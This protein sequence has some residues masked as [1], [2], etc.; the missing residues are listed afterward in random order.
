MDDLQT[1]G[2]PLDVLEHR[3]SLEPVGTDLDS[4]P[5]QQSELM[6]VGGLVVQTDQGRRA[7]AES[8]RGQGAVGDASTQ[9]PATRVV[10]R[11]VARGCADDDDLDR[12]AP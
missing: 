6:G 7:Q 3:S 12:L 4:C 5:A 8:S 11:D 9:P 1:P 2:G 10:R